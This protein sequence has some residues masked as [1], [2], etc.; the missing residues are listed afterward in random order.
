MS[1]VIENEKD[2]KLVKIITLIIIYFVIGV[3]ALFTIGVSKVDAAE[4]NLG[5]CDSLGDLYNTNPSIGGSGTNI[6][7]TN[8]CLVYSQ[9]ANTSINLSSNSYDY[10]I[11]FDLEY[12]TRDNWTNSVNYTIEAGYMN[13]DWTFIKSSNCSV[14]FVRNQTS[15]SLP[16]INVG[17]Y[18]RTISGYAVCKNVPKQ[19]TTRNPSLRIFYDTRPDTTQGHQVL[20]FTGSIYMSYNSVATNNS[21]TSYNGPT[22]ND[23]NNNFNSVINN[24]NANTQNIINNN[25]S[26]TQQIIDSNNQ[27]KESVDD[28]NDTLNDS[29]IDNPSS[30]LNGMN[31]YFGSNGVISD[32]LL[33]PV[34]MFQSIVNTIDGTCSPFSLG[35]LYGHDLI[36]PCINLSSRLGTALYGVI[37]VLIC[38]FFILT[39]R[40][41][42][43]DIFEHFTSLNMGGNELE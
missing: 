4:I 25:N 39:I 10:T 8:G 30:A 33:L 11:D 14:T 5:W 36:M 17:G 43:V 28:L 23:I 1:E 42:F 13:T 41:K 3:F 34:R 35:T 6:P 24:N 19:S 22:K 21:S 31:N 29:S 20:G 2:F 38:G 7:A 37:D 26:N 9:Y 18:K 16:L 15:V 32:L 40:K 12:Y 27:T